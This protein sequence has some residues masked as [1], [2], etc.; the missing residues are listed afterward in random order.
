MKKILVHTPILFSAVFLLVPICSMVAFIFGY[1]FHLYHGSITVLVMTALLIAAT[2]GM[3]WL[4]VQPKPW[5]KTFAAL[6]MPVLVFHAFFFLLAKDWLTFVCIAVSLGCGVVIFVQYANPRPWKIACGIAATLLVILLAFVLLATSL[7]QGFGSRTVVKTAVSPGQAY[8]ARVI[9]A[10][11]G[12]LGGH[13]IVEVQQIN[14]VISIGIGQFVKQP[15]CVYTGPWGESDHMDLH[16]EN[17][18]ILVINGVPYQ[19]ES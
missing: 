9:D 4:N 17:D 19:V 7:L 14:P 8:E 16:W 6:L 5:G 15:V 13:T 2:A 10:N 1:D 11:E 18:G 12:A 3:R